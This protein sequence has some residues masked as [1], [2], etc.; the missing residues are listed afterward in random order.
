MKNSFHERL[1]IALEK[2]A[3]SQSEMAEN[4]GISL[5]AI[6]HFVHGRREPNLRNLAKIVRFLPRTYTRWLITGE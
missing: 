4:T 3:I 6:N 5:A 2:E 1:Q